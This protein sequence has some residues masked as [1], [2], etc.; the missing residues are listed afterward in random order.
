MIS[1]TRLKLQLRQTSYVE[2]LYCLGA[3]SYFSVSRNTVGDSWCSTCISR[4][5]IDVKECIKDY[6]RPVTK[7]ESWLDKLVEDLKDLWAQQLCTRNSWKESD[8]LGLMLSYLT[9]DLP[10]LRQH[11]VTNF[12][13]SIPHKLY[14]SLVHINVNRFSST[15]NKYE[16]SQDQIEFFLQK[17]RMPR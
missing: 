4:Q 7:C 12:W 10:L 14:L 9:H 2:S 13:S 15:K 11:G 5:G 8:G 3:A 1:S 17:R 6:F 16:A